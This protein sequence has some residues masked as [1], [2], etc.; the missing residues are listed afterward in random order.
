MSGSRSIVFWRRPGQQTMVSQNLARHRLTLL[1]RYI[2]EALTQLH[3]GRLERAKCLLEVVS[4]LAICRQ[5]KR[6]AHLPPL[7]A[8]ED[9]RNDNNQED[10]NSHADQNCTRVHHFPRW[11][12][13]SARVR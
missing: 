2:R 13:K 5:A 1:L 8:S 9:R 12:A 3:F 4:Q 7:N 6:L 10:R 11:V